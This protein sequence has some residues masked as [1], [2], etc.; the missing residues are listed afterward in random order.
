MS[1]GR[2]ALLLD[3]LE[4][5]MREFVLDVMK[6]LTLSSVLQD[7]NRELAEEGSAKVYVLF[8]PLLIFLKGLE[9]RH[10]LYRGNKEPQEERKFFIRQE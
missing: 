1:G 9:L 8:E 6:S 7:H 10:S 2:L 4:H 3:D 5:V